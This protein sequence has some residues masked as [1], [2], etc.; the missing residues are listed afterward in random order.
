MQPVLISGPG[1]WME[2]EATRQLAAVAQLEGCVR[3]AGMPDRHG[4]AMTNFDLLIT[5]GVGPIEARR[6]VAQLAARLEELA[7][8]RGL[9]VLEVV[10][11]G[12]DE[13]VARSITLRVR[14]D[15]VG[16]LSDELGTHVLV[17]R[18][19]ARGRSSRKRWF[20]AVSAHPRTDA[21]TDADVAAIP[22]G[23]LVITACRAG[24][25]G[26]Q[27]VNKVS[28]AVRVHHVPTGIVIRSAGARSQHANLDQ[29]LRRLAGLLRER[30]DARR[31]ADRSVRRDAHYR[32]ERGR[33]IRRYQLD[34]DGL[35]VETGPS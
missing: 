32:L 7:E 2:S 31:A 29:A 6:F 23:A 13:G 15:T 33:A 14:G 21:G 11:S 22:R 4:E 28:S 19:P 30:A 27:H 34:A 3:A 1:V 20:A 24:G 12:G 5:S 10:E 26:G 18:S 16:Q 8:Q 35:L 25:P 9:E 17:Q